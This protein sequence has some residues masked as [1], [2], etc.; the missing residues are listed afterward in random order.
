MIQELEVTES[1]AREC[2]EVFPW[3]GLDRRT[4][5]GFWLL[6]SLG[7]R[8]LRPGG[9]ELT[10][11]MLAELDIRSSDRVVEYAPGMGV[12]AA[13]TWERDPLHY[14][15]IERDAA[16]ARLLRERMPPRDGW[17][18]LNADAVEPLPFAD[19]EVSVV[20]G[21]SMLTI[22]NESAKQQI[23]RE[24]HRVLQPGGRY[25]IQEISIVP[26]NTSDELAERIRREL[27]RAVCHP[28]R[29]KTTTS[30]REFLLGNGFE[31]TAEFRRPVLLLERDR[32]I[33]DE[34]MEATSRFLWNTLQDP[35]ATERIRMI[36]S[37]FRKYQAH[38]CGNCV[39]CRRR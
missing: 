31:I 19:H 3:D 22:H 32:L 39:V 21:E 17:R 7:K 14:T 16:A 23:I 26:E 27:I 12:T 37:V 1:L 24:V 8:V 2:D 4:M 20:Y 29:P 10:R 34:G 30:W 33:E 36:Q 13:L 25:A 35:V 18:V 38:L 11:A 5:P 15:A 9:I 6:G 28:A